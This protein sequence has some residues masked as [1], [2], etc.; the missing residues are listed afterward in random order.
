MSS[1]NKLS[2]FYDIYQN[3]VKTKLQQDTAANH[4]FWPQFDEKKQAK[5]SKTEYHFENN[6]SVT[7]VNDNIYYGWLEKKSKLSNLLGQWRER[8]I[9]LKL[10]YH[11]YNYSKSHYNKNHIGCL[12]Q[13]NSV[14]L[15]TYQQPI[16]VSATLHTMLTTATSVL[17]I[18]KYTSNSVALNNDIIDIKALMSPDMVKKYSGKYYDA[19]SKWKIKDTTK[20]IR[21]IQIR[22]STQQAT[23][24]WKELV[25][26]VIKEINSNSLKPD[27]LCYFKRKMCQDYLLLY[28]HR[29]AQSTRRDKTK[30]DEAIRI[31]NQV[32]SLN[33]KSS[34]ILCL[35]IKDIH[36]YFGD[37]KN[38]KTKKMTQLQ[39]ELYEKMGSLYNCKEID[40]YSYCLLLY[41]MR[42]FEKLKKLL[43]NKDMITN[44]NITVFQQLVFW[45]EVGNYDKLKTILLN[46]SNI[47][48]DDELMFWCQVSSNIKDKKSIKSCSEHIKKMSKKIIE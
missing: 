29:I 35:F 46:N 30:Y 40:C 20:Q 39:L 37:H 44:S 8:F 4:Y 15:L 33:P 16:D 2:E 32:H 41:E 27:E 22:C 26:D 6:N 10:D 3:R 43:T 13:C 1:K 12:R 47:S 25:H 11:D 45:N 24:F 9:V 7:R 5:T 42:A 21:N 38:K 36:E 18:S 34:K 17:S 31:Y 19:Q 28:A 23:K 48:I 14:T